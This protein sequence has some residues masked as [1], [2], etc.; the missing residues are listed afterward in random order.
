M[1][2]WQTASF[3]FFLYAAGCAL[4][5]RRLGVG[6]RWRAL[7][8][9]AAGFGLTAFS[10]RLEHVWVL[11]DWIIP[12]VLLLTG[13][14]GTGVMF[15]APMPR[16]ERWLAA[17]DERLHV[18]WLAS[19]LPRI[20]AEVLEI[21]Y[22]GVYVLVPVGLLL[23]LRFAAAPDP[24]RYWSVVLVTAYICCGTLPWLQTRPPRAL[25]AEA[26]WRARVRPFN[27]GMLKATSIQVNTIPSGHAAQAL[28]AALLAA[29]APPGLLVLMFAAALAVAAG[30]VLGR[31]HYAADA[32]SGWAVAVAVWTMAA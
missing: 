14:W 9:A 10:V 18:R 25:E 17:F 15:V 23:Q 6:Q 24:A 4:L 11:H 32:L 16:A 29:S 22:A 5:R 19:S 31:Y 21:A 7:A 28:A 27:L 20:T 30:A 1:A 2:L 26:P 13:Y 3:V 12:P 8:L